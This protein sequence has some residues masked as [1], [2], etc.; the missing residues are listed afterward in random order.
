MSSERPA[1]LPDSV[2]LVDDEPAVLETLPIALKRA[3]LSVRTAS[4]AEDALRLIEEEAFGA[5]VTDKNL[6]GVN[7]IELMK[8][9]KA[10]QPHCACLIITAYVSTASVLEALQLGAS[11]Y[12]LKP[13]DSLQLVTQ[14]VKRAIEERR[15][16]AE[17]A[18]LAEALR[19][20]EKR[21][22]TTEQEVFERQ[23]ELDLF[24]NVMELRV[25]EATKGLLARLAEI[26]S[27]LNAEKNRRDSQRQALL[28]VAERCRAEA[29]ALQGG[30]AEALERIAALVTQAAESL[31]ATGG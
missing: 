31:S 23:T 11:D 24:Q 18:A 3:G 10:R 21:L 9:V 2:L 13:F 20:M 15:V 28:E 4:N 12:I 30:G 16:A 1:G 26:E 14:R 22:R 17:R 25:E 5:L 19:G 8:R 7:G 6:P 29:K 27:D